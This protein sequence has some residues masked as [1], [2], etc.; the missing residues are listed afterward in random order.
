MAF[1]SW[2]G[3]A[4]VAA[5]QWSRGCLLRAHENDHTQLMTTDDLLVFGEGRRQTLLNMK[6]L[7]LAQNER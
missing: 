6:G 7:I 2:K 3:L 4:S 5:M 1:S